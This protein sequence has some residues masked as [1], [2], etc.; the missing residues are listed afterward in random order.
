MEN[1]QIFIV[2]HEQIISEFMDCDQSLNP[3]K[4]TVVNVRPGPIHVDPR[5]KVL[6][7]TD[8]PSYAPLGPN[9][10]ESEALLNV[11]LAGIHK[12][13]NYIGFLQYDKEL[14]PLSRL[15]RL[16]WK[17]RGFTESVSNQV[18]KGGRLHVSFE[19][20]SIRRDYRQAIMADFERPLELQGDGR[21]CYLKILEDYNKFSGTSYS[22]KDLK[23]TRRINLV[24]CFF[25][26]ANTFEKMM[27]F[28]HWVV[29]HQ[30][31]DLLDPDRRFRLQGGLAERYFGVFLA[32]SGLKLID[33][34]V[35][36]HRIPPLARH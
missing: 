19:T 31:L 32:F 4:F 7:I 23:K 11:Y 2:T 6:N 8:L 26:D 17:S 36:H 12:E 30:N 35:P 29:Q 16:T 3:Q 10:A 34:S 14:K 15:G 20:H 33:M 1:W 21:N 28:F 25:T 9:W 5:F 18:K 22:L 13:Y 24:S 27:E